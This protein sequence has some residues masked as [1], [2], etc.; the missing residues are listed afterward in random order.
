MIADVYVA[1]IARAT[2]LS[3]PAVSRIFNGDRTP[4][5]ENA[6]AIAAYLQRR[7][8]RKFRVEDLMSVIADRV[9]EG[10]GKRRAS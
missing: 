1:E 3:G 7:L 4:R 2:K 5:L 6:V 9:K 10:R 8:K